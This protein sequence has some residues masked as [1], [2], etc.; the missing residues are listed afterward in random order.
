MYIPFLLKQRCIHPGYKPKSK[1]AWSGYQDELS[2]KR[3]KNKIILLT[4]VKIEI[5]G[6]GSR[7]CGKVLIF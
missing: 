3:K 7:T 2:R 6:F 1:C 4:N 5:F